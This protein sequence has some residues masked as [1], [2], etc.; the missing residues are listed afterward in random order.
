MNGKLVCIDGLPFRGRVSGK[1]AEFAD[2][3]RLIS[4]APL[5]SE[6]RPFAQCSFA[7]ESQEVLKADD[8]GK[9]FRRETNADAEVAFKLARTPAN[10]VRYFVNASLAARAND[11]LHG[12]FKPRA[13]SGRNQLLQE[14]LFHQLLALSVIAR[15]KHSLLEVGSFTTPNVAGGDRAIRKFT[16]R[17]RQKAVRT[18]RAKAHTH[19]C[20]ISGRLQQ[21]KP[22]ELTDN[23]TARLAFPLACSAVSACS[24]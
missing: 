1:L 4:I 19:Y 12:G 16:E 21:E 20:H 5:N 3:M 17:K 13:R 11:L 22:R 9:R 15:F 8:A 6:I 14:K 23:E 7:H 10:P 2:H 24:D 18:A